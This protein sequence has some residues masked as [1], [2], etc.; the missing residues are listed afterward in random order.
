MNADAFLKFFIC[1]HLRNLRLNNSPA[2]DLSAAALAKAE[3]DKALKEI[4]EKIG[5]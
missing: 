1:A 5:V 3:T 2:R 4:L